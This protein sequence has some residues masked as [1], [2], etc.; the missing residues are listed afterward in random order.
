MVG[1]STPHT[2]MLR[3]MGRQY[4]LQVCCYKCIGF[5]NRVCARQDACLVGQAVKENSALEGVGWCS[6]FKNML[7]K[8][9]N[10]E[11]ELIN[12]GRLVPVD[13]KDIVRRFQSRLLGLEALNCE[14]IETAVSNELG[15]MVRNCPDN[16]RKGFKVFK[17][18]RWFYDESRKFPVLYAL[19]DAYDIRVLAKF[20]C[21]MHWLA[22]EKNRSN[23]VGRSERRCMC[24]ASN[25]REDEMHVIF[26]A[27]YVS[28][29]NQFAHIFTSQVY[30]DL[31]QAYENGSGDVD[32]CLKT[33]FNQDDPQFVY[34]FAGYLR[35]S[36]E[37]RKRYLTA[38]L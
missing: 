32:E 24:C 37:I 2:V 18:R 13:K 5:W 19:E 3:E 30:L 4:L 29:R 15:S 38:S 21:G 17:H 25:E 26:C 33:F 6:N 23:E 16:I 12:S 27:A 34:E 28:L 9:A 20:R 14:Q 31:K 22:T 7:L 10:V 11:I 36:I 35:R 1:K 8:T